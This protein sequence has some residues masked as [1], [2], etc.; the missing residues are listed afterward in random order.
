MTAESYRN[1]EPNGYQLSFFSGSGSV[2]AST[3]ASPSGPGSSGACTSGMIGSTAGGFAADG[4]GAALRTGGEGPR[5]SA[6][7]ALPS[8]SGVAAGAAGASARP[9]T[10][11]APRAVRPASLVGP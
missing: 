9:G 8:R 11:P 7:S 5:G 4:A 10:L 2:S 1:S 6:G 3:S